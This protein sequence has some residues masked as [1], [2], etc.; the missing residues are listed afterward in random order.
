MGNQ[1]E[2]ETKP[3]SKFLARVP[4]GKGD[5]NQSKDDGFHLECAREMSLWN[6]TWSCPVGS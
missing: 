4:A 2:G 3:H 5:V 1:G 6:R